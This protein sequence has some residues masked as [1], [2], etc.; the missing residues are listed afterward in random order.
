[1]RLAGRRLLQSPWLF[2]GPAADR[3][4][5]RADYL[6]QY[7][8]KSGNFASRPSAHQLG[9]RDCRDTVPAA[10]TSSAYGAVCFGKA[11]DPDGEN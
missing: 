8:W 4:R 2:A 1:M 3:L 10:L 6:P 7:A 9:H 11:L 5:A